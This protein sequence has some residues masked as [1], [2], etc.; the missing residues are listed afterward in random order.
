MEQNVNEFEFKS[1]KEPKKMDGALKGVIGLTVGTAVVALGLFGMS[2][3]NDTGSQESGLPG[4]PVDMIMEA[5][6]VSRDEAVLHVEGAEITA[7]E[8]L[9]WVI[10]VADQYAQMGMSDWTMDIGGVTMGDYVLGTAID[11]AIY[12]SIIESKAYEF[13]AGPTDADHADYAERLQELRVS[14][15]DESGADSNLSFQYWLAYMGLTEETFEKLSMV[16]YCSQ[17][18]QQ[19]LFGPG[20]TQEMSAEDIQVWA[21]SYGIVRVKHILIADELGT[22]EGMAVALGAAEAVYDEV[23]T[24]GGSESAFDVA[25]SMHT[26]DVDVYGNPNNPDGYVYDDMGYVVGTENMLV[27]SFTQAGTELAIGEVSQPV[28]SDYGYHVMMRL[29]L[30]LDSLADT[31]VAVSMAGLID[32]W[33]AEAEILEGPMFDMVSNMDAYNSFEFI[34][35]DIVMAMEETLYPE[36]Y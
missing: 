3:M 28:E 26:Y 6:G 22:E 2:M 15:G 33:L 10:S 7:E 31:A 27:D 12:H 14:M 20:G 35:M 4:V 34:R 5:T 8:L 1:E 19:L 11:T 23:M 24:Q 17:N 36:G 29:P 16:G 18:L 30:D 21:D 32:L 25:M 13:G 9:Y